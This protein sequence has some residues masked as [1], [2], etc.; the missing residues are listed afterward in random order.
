MANRGSRTWRRRL[1]GL[2]R[3]FFSRR[4]ASGEI[5]AVVSVHL[6]AIKMGKHEGGIGDDAPYDEGYRQSPRRPV[7]DSM[8][9]NSSIKGSQNRNPNV[10]RA[11]SVHR[12]GELAVHRGFLA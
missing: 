6:P 12:R 11:D 8:H 5:F 3:P 10:P 2:R 1:P 9:E 7:K 4:P